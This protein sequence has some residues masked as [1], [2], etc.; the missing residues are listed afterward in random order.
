MAY[1]ADLW[2][3]WATITGMLAVLIIVDFMFLGENHF[4]YDPNPRNVV[5]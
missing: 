5:Y 1:S 3:Q 4:V 2:A